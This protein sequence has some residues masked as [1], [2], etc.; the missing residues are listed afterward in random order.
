MTGSSR[1]IQ[2]E[3]PVLKPD[4]AII[5]VN[6]KNAKDTL[7]CIG[8]ISR[9]SYGKHMVVVV[10]NA[11]NDGSYELIK[12]STVP[13]TILRSDQNV[14]FAAACNL[15][16]DFL[17]SQAPSYVW[18]LNNDTVVDEHALAHLV[19][20]AESGT[21]IG[22]VGS[23]ILDL[24]NTSRVLCVG[25]GLISCLTGVSQHVTAY[26]KDLSLDYICGASLLIRW[27]AI[28][29]VGPLREDYF[30]YWE[31]ADYCARLARSNWALALAEESVVYHAESTTVGKK[32]TRFDYFF[33]RA[34][35]IFVREHFKYHWP[36]PLLISLGGRLVRR[37][38]TK[39]LAGARAILKGTLHGVAGK[40]QRPS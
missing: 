34:S 14:G 40:L 28:V 13:V 6:Y 31:D 16:I 38:F 4:V 17:K 8:S 29:S 27:R 3:T 30:L 32:S 37:L 15:A 1:S 7:R 10:D 35:V 18:L 33:S 21:H 2:T 24:S 5:L 20:K 36:V 9:M 19:A 23:K 11:S 25:G 12:E 39:N 22:A 26:A